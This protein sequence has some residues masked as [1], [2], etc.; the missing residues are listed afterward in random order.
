[1]TKY[2]KE[3]YW[4]FIIAAI[5][6]FSPSKIVAYGVPYIFLGYLLAKNIEVKRTVMTL[7]ALLAV[8]LLSYFFYY[9][10]YGNTVFQNHLLTLLTYS[11]FIPV[12]IVDNRKIAQPHLFK[13]IFAFLSILF[14]LQGSVGIIQA[15]YGAIILNKGFDS[16]NGDH[17][18]GTIHLSLEPEL[19]FSNPMFAVNMTFIGMALLVQHFV[20][21]DGKKHRLFIGF[22]SLILASVMHVLLLAFVSA[23]LFYLVIRP[24]FAFITNSVRTVRARLKRT[25]IKLF[26]IIFMF[27]IIGVPVYF[28]S[29]NVSLI[30]SFVT[31]TFLAQTPKA[32]ITIDAFDKLPDRYPLFPVF[33]FG[34][35]QF[36]SRA[37]LIGSGVYLGGVDNPQSPPLLQSKINPVADKVLIPYLYESQQKKYLGSTGFPHYSWLSVYSEMGGIVFFS[38]T[39]FALYLI[40]RVIKRAGKS[41]AHRFTAFLFCTGLGL[42][43]LLGMHENYWEVPQAI[44]LGVL[45]LKIMYAG[46]MHLENFNDVTYG[47]LSRETFEGYV[48]NQQQEQVSLDDKA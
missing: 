18:E 6:C 20:Y 14:L 42:L 30:E 13:K 24:E 21:E 48:N 40:I 23:I 8:S 43:Y 26:L 1:M 5:I 34:P 44:F 35:G 17:V 10:L 22:L 39:L 25:S 9:S 16:V 38:L 37:S 15:A 27:F 7:Y 31:K 4:A 2:S 12:L 46:V 36:T 29:H 28:L 47:L 33:G 19:S 32:K 45:I 41:K 11:S 3:F